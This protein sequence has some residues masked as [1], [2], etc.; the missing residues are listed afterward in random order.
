MKKMRT[1]LIGAC[2][3]LFTSLVATP[4]IAGSDDFAGPYVAIQ[5]SMHGA[6]ING[7]ATNS[8]AEVTNGTLG[9]VFGAAGFEAGYLFPAGDNV[10]LGLNVM[11]QP[12]DGKISIDSGAGDSAD[13][14]VT[15]TIGDVITASIM[16]M[17]SIT[18]T[19]ALYIKAGITDADLSWTGDVYKDL[20]SSMRGESYAVGSRTMY[21][22]GAFLQTEFGYNDFDTLNIQKLTGSGQAVANPETVYGAVSIGFR[23]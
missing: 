18:D 7:N 8:N 13:E 16:P 5:G 17:F 3:L 22:G 21:S 23:F 19:T 14:D 12:G 2:A 6:I 15:L 20:N 9:D 10:L 11:L 4:S 1:M